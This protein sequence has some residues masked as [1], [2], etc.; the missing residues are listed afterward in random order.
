MNIREELISLLNERLSSILSTSP[1]ST[2]IYSWLRRLFAANLGRLKTIVSLPRYA[3]AIEIE[4][5]WG[6]L[7][8]CSYRSIE[9]AEQLSRVDHL[10]LPEFKRQFLCHTDTDCKCKMFEVAEITNY[11]DK[12]PPPKK[13]IHDGRKILKRLDFPTAPKFSI[14]LPSKG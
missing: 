11:Y 8:E 7:S 2:D 6:S 13:G 14:D 5:A 1:V 3:A 10:S 4:E 12:R 9:L